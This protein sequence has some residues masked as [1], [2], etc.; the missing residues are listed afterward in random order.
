MCTV[1]KHIAVII[2][3]CHY[4]ESSASTK[5]QNQ[6]PSFN[7]YVCGIKYLQINTRTIHLQIVIKLAKCNV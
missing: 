5:L 1:Y 6:S 4:F 2:S 3:Y 7:G